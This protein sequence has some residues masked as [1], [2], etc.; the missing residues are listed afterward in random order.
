MAINL[1]RLVGFESFSDQQIAELAF[2]HGISNSRTVGVLYGLETYIPDVRLGGVLDLL[3][4]LAGDQKESDWLRECELIDLLA[5]LVT[6]RLSQQEQIEVPRLWSW[7]EPLAHRYGG[8]RERRKDLAA[9]LLQKPELC[10]ELQHFVLFEAVGDDNLR[11]R[12]R[13]LH[14][15]VADLYPDNAR[16]IELFVEL[17]PADYADERWRD[18]L[19]IARHDQ[20]DSDAV[21]A[22]AR[23][24]AMRSTDG[25]KHL[26]QW[27][28]PPEWELRERKEQLKR[29]AKEQAKLETI[30]QS[31]R[32]NLDGV[33]IGKYNCIIDP[34]RCYLGLIY[35]HKEEV[36][37]QR[38]TAWLSKEISVAAFH[39]FEAYLT[40]IP[41]HPTATD[42]ADSLAQHKSWDAGY[43]IVTALAE[44]L[45]NGTGFADLRDERL[46]AGLFV[47]AFRHFS[48]ESIRHDL[49]VALSTELQARGSWEQTMRLF[50]EPQLVA[51]R[52]HV[53]WL[54]GSR[55][56]STYGHDLAVEWLHRFDGLPWAA[57][58]RLVNLLWQATRYTDLLKLART[59]KESTNVEQRHLWTV[60]G[61]LLDFETFSTQFAAAPPDPSLIWVLEEYTSRN[62]WQSHEDTTLMPVIAEWI[63]RNFRKL[64][65]FCAEFPKGDWVGRSHPR[66]ASKY[67]QELIFLLGAD[68]SDAA[69]TA[70]LRLR[71]EAEDGYSESIRRALSEQ[72][73][74]IA[75]AEHA[76]LTLPELSSIL[77]DGRP[78]SEADLQTFMLEELKL[79]AKKIR[80]DD[81][82]SWRGFYD[83]Q[84]VPFDEER[85]RDHLLG[86]LRQGQQLV[87]LEPETHVADDKEVDITCSSGN[88]RLPIEIKGQWHRDL[89]AAVRS[90]ARWFVYARLACW[91]SGY[92]SGSLV[93]RT[94]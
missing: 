74:A 39:G 53:C 33:R 37:H 80:S 78:N 86:L 91:R 55:K 46:M 84:G 17:N 20:A 12:A 93:W 59:R 69:R 35:D 57:E 65:S 10:R 14:A 43:I 19:Y 42:I 1:L 49:M 9:C 52:E 29:K 61:L 28:T 51:R 47:L 83:D 88:W 13:T 67:L 44:R 41:P 16:V 23:P 75:D 40:A 22:A 48:D 92:L 21:R 64:W 50:H 85:C 34:A 2:T 8:T 30:R 45:R 3:A 71:D 58:E 7:L 63:V 81:V 70:L 24:F 56:S 79:V 54:E 32:D 27:G 77:A 15:L 25:E 31:Y 89:W 36:P 6:R 26:A 73:R 68:T 4:K 72:I 60:L 5:S 18:L 94:S 66:D 62:F 38:I 11:F 82:D 76:T 87:E 90:A